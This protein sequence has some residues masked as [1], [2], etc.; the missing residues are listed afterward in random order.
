[1]SVDVMVDENG[2]AGTAAAGVREPSFLPDELRE[3]GWGVYRLDVERFFFSTD[4][5]HDPVREH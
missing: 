4:T 2:V 5:H 1:M 3:G